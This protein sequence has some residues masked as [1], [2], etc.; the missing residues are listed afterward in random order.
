[1]KEENNDIAIKVNHVY[2][3]F[4]VYYDR[5]NTLKE[6]L[7]FIGRNKKREKREILNDINIDI[8]KG[9]TVALIGDVHGFRAV[10]QRK[11][12]TFKIN[13]TNNFSQQR[14]N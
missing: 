10:G 13:D 5:A 14:N 3:S 9:E 4:N 1:M 2:K 12:N 11:I 7:L 8:K 6:R